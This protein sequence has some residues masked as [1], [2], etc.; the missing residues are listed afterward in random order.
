MRR[1]NSSWRVVCT[2]LM[3]C[4]TAIAEFFCVCNHSGC[5][6]LSAECG[7]HVP[8]RESLDLA[9]LIEETPH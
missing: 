9:A 1:S 3:Y 6:I 8:I 7:A 4:T 2:V 5:F